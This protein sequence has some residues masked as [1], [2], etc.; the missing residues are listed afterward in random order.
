MRRLVFF[1][2]VSALPVL[3]QNP[4]ELTVD[5]IMQ[6]PDTWIGAWPTDVFWTDDGEHLY[7]RWNPQGRFESDSLFKA[8]VDGGEAVQLT[9]PERRNLPP[10]FQGWHDNRLAYNADF[11]E[12]IFER[13]G[14]LFIYYLERNETIRL[15]RTSQQESSPRFSPDGHRIVYREGDNLFARE[16]DGIEQLTDIRE[17]SEP[18]EDDPSE[19]DAFLEAQQTR[20]FDVLSERARRDSLREE[21]Q[22]REE[23]AENLPP[24]YYVGDG[25]VGQLQMSPAG[26]F[27]TYVLGEDADATRT[28]LTNYV[29]SSGYAEEITARPKV[30]SPSGE[31]T[32][33]IQDLERDTTYAVDL[34]TLP[35]AFDAADF[36]REQG[37]EA[38]STRKLYSHGPYWS[39]DGR[40]AVLDIRSSD[41]KHR[42]IALL[43][44]E[45]G[46]V[47]SLD[48]QHDDAW[49]AGPGISWWGGRS[50]VGWMADN[51][52]FWFQSEEIDTEVRL[53]GADLRA[54][55]ARFGRGE[56]G[57]VGPV[58]PTN[59]FSHLWVVDVES[60]EVE[61]LTSGPFEVSNPQLS[62]D[63]RTWYFQSS[64]GSP[65][66]RHVYRMDADGGNRTRLTRLPGRN[67][68]ALSPNEEW[69]A[70]MYSQSNRPPE[71]VLEPAEPMA[72][73]GRQAPIRYLTASPTEDWLAY[74]WRD[75]EIIHIIASDGVDV[76]ARIYRPQN[77]NGAAVLF[78]HGA[79][80]LQNVHRWWSSY[81]REYQFHNLLADRG[82]VV[83]DLDYRA[84]AGYG[85]DWRTA[86][87]RHMGGRDLQDYVDASGYV[88]EEFGIDPERVAIYGG[89]YGGFIAL[90]A[91]F[92]EPEHFGGGAALRS[93]TDWA[94]YNHGYTANILNTPVT[95]SLAYARSS[96]IAFAAG[97]EDPLL[98]AHGLID[99]NVQP[100][101]IFRLSQRLIELRKENWELA[102]YPVEPHSFSEPTSWADEY[103]RILA[104]IERSVG[105]GR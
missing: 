62:K 10:R 60:G 73:D 96:P 37:M 72:Q 51:R 34:T 55:E 64:E 30:G 101:D 12:R 50:D 1:I 54:I 90:M 27:I 52:R 79:G 57:R 104:L 7:F 93:V 75:P 61:A 19:Q 29:T 21:A 4:P 102:I 17:G 67:D 100:Q 69:L 28:Q 86:V 45:D 24:T 43:N 16:A 9:P 59:R 32:L 78:V 13:D 95:D 6:D 97:L 23:D 103:R 56:N 98:M 36:Q 58:G 25:E 94:H 31:Q 47:S 81:F 88:G 38:D 15:T 92:T 49:I 53:S 85:R 44:P 82:Y 26:R 80:Y 42:W 99:D 77:P 84:S 35:G 8:R 2:A 65:H 83:L 5:M 74:P 66:E 63:G 46:T 70:L 39:P 22:E 48:H 87:Y 41:N 89:S 40:Y 33:Y 76:P 3:A 105:P 14:D 71:V 68:F 20:F 91:L 11:S 18:D